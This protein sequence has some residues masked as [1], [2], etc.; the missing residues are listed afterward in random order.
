MSK[1]K[2]HY[3]VLKVNS[4]VQLPELKLRYKELLLNT[5]PDKLGSAQDSESVWR[6]RKVTINHIQEAYKV[7]SDAT[8]K[9]EYDKS[10]LDNAK[11]NG[12]YKFGEGVD[13]VSLDKFGFDEK[14]EGYIL[15]CPRCQVH[16][17]FKLTDDLLEE[18][19]VEAEGR[20]DG[21]F[22]VLTQCTACSLWLKVN[23]Y[24]APEVDGDLENETDVHGTIPQ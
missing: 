12:V 4:A 10:L 8:L 20:T 22:Q 11:K 2:T 9:A 15:N 1:N 14:D 13:E 5:H 16:D 21:M 19:A 23:F 17:G 24:E 18:Y 3:E 7:L 6:D